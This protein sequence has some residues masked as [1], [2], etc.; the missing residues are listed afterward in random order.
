MGPSSTARPC[1]DCGHPASG[2][3]CSRCGQR[4]D[5][6][7]RSLRHWFRE[8]LEETLSLDGT[9]LRSLRAL[10]L[11]PG[12]LT[13]EWREGRRASWTTPFRLYLLSSLVYFTASVLVPIGGSF[14][15]G[16]T[17]PADLALRDAVQSTQE[18]AL[19][20]VAPQVLIALVP[21]LA[22]WLRI[23]FPGSRFFV[24]HLVHAVHIQSALYVIL[25]GLFVGPLLPIPAR[26]TISFAV[27]LAMLVYLYR[28]CRRVY[29]VGPLH[30]GLG[31][32]V[33]ATAHFAAVMI[34]LGLVVSTV[35]ADPLDDLR[36]AETSYWDLRARWDRG[37]S[38]ALGAR[39]LRVATRYRRLEMH[40]LHAEARAHA[41]EMLL[42]GDSIVDARRMAEE[43]LVGSPGHPLLLSVAAR[44]AEEMGD[45][46]AAATWSRRLIAAEARDGLA[47]IDPRHRQDLEAARARARALLGYS[48]DSGA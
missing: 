9:L 1:P 24:E 36:A 48:I 17:P 25:L 23:V 7:P 8:A 5:V 29:G 31:A 45:R 18:A 33:V 21:L 14:S 3:Y 44:A 38:T 47:T 34:T 37:D 28:S 19:G 41:A 39:A 6:D 42:T 40:L 26:I 4:T 35:A 13:V 32:A 43:G 46:G 27:L 15:V 2:A 11:R 30:A 22:L 10:G 16:G 20:A 12:F